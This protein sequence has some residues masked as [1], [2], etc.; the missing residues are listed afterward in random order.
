MGRET[1]KSTTNDT[2]P[3]TGHT[4]P[5][6]SE[7]DPPT[8]NQVFQTCEFMGTIL[9]KKILKDSFIDILPINMSGSKYMGC[10]NTLPTWDG[11]NALHIKKL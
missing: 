11:Q 6:P 4:L 3:S 8:V 7:I 10:S 1:P 5:N 9:N 2:H